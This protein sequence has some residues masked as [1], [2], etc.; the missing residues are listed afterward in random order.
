MV[1]QT[2]HP[3]EFCIDVFCRPRSDADNQFIY[4]IRWS[5]NKATVDT[6]DSQ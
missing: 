6:P 4:F 5:D 3:I 2:A 1:V